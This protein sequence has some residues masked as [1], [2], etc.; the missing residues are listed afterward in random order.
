MKPWSAANADGRIT[1]PLR[2]DGQGYSG[3]NVLILWA[4]AMGYD[5]DFTARTVAYYG[6][7]GEEYVEA[8]SMV[9]VDS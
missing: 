2:H 1:R 5:V 3:I 4:S 8:Y 6:C 9:E 7:N